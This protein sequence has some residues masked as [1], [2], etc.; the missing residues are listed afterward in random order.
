V[1][2]NP[3]ANR[4]TLV[5]STGR[6]VPNPSEMFAASYLKLSLGQAHRVDDFVRYIVW[7]CES[8]RPLGIQFDGNLY[9][10]VMPP[11]TD[12]TKLRIFHGDDPERLRVDLHS[13]A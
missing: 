10:A 5:L 2:K 7:R 8:N 3:A 12:G 11:F 1:P 13:L 6:Y 9:I 4:A